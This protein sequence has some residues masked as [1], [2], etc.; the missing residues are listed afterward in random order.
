MRPDSA[1]RC[2]RIPRR[3]PGVAE[4]RIAT[5]SENEHSQSFQGELNGRFLRDVPYIRE[6]EVRVDY[7]YTVLNNLILREGQLYANSG[8]RA[9]H[10]VEAFARL[11]LQG[12]HFLQGAYTYLDSHSSQTGAMRGMPNHWFSLSAVV[13]VVKSHF[14]LNATLNVL[15]PFEDPKRYPSGSGSIP[16]ATA[17]ENLT[18]ITFD[19]APPVALLQLGARVRL[20]ADRISASV[21]FYNV[22]D[23]HYYLPNPVY[24]VVPQ[25]PAN[26]IAAPGFSV[27]ASLAYHP[28]F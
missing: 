9:I 23:Q 15:G 5:R 10:S 22:L 1:R 14:D 4:L 25:A 11:Y 19:R 16:G 27:F 6:L 20:A 2:F 24:D 17:S 12:D 7:S 13:N 21:Q 8:N 26:L 18:A 3:R 28:R